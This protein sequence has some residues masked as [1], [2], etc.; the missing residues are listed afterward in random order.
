MSII[1]L[2]EEN[3]T[4]IKKEGITIVD[5]FATWC[6]PCRMLSPVLEE[7]A[8]NSDITIIK[9]DVDKHENLA[10]EYKIMSVPT[11]IFFKDGVEIDKHIGFISLD[12]IEN[13]VS[14]M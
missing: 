13:K 2:E 14:N 11:L 3:L 9:V 8:N 7:L 6:G 12:D 4:N 5:F 10:R 1:H